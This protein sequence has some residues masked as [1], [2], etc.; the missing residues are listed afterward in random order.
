MEYQK[1][2]NLLDNKPDHLSKFRAKIWIGI[3]D[4]SRGNYN[5]NSD[6]RFKTTVLKSSLCYHS[7]AQILV[8]GR[9]TITGNAV[10]PTGRT[11]A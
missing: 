4:Q 6:I 9:I 8:K 11:E 7:D 2:V 5:A 1:I 10:T 3:N